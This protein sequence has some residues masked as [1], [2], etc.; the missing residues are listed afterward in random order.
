MKQLGMVLILL[1]LAGCGDDGDDG[2]ATMT[3]DANA[4]IVAVGFSEIGA[5]AE[6][7]IYYSN[8][9]YSLSLGPGRIFWTDGITVWFAD[10]DIEPGTQG[11]DAPL[12][13]LLLRDGD[14]GRGRRYEWYLDLGVYFEDDYLLKVT[15]DL[16]QDGLPSP[17]DLYPIRRLPPQK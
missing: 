11:K 15:L 4:A 14:D 13:G 3:F 9:V 7:G 10:V 1:L 12:E 5:I 16:P 8:R 6:G 17:E 2:P